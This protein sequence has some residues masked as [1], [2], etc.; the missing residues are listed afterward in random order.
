[1]DAMTKQSEQP[2][3]PLTAIRKL[4][5][6]IAEMFQPD[7]IILF[8]SYAY[9]EPDAGSDV[10][11]LVVMPARNEITQAVRI[12]LAIEHPFPFDLSVRTPENLR[13]RLAE[14]D[15]FLGEIV[16]KGRVLHDKTHG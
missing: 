3:I 8:G 11:L 16:S 14:G 9:G 15:S 2:L 4:A 7:K 5:G 6:E 12:R 10:D 13:R 1:M